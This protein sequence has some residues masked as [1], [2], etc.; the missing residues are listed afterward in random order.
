M[1]PAFQA[2]GRA[3]FTLIELLVVIAIIAV[4]IGLLLPAVQKVREAANRMQ[5]ANNL[6]QIGLAIHSYHDAQGALPYSRRDPGDTW[7]VLLMPYIEQ[8]TLYTRWTGDRRYYLQTRQARETPVPLYF[9]PSRR[10]PAGSPLSLELDDDNGRGTHVPGALSDYAA[11]SGNPS[12]YADYN[13]RDFET[14]TVPTGLTASNGCF[15]RRTTGWRPV[16]F[17]TVTD[18]LSN[19]IF[20]GEKHIRPGRFGRSPDLAIYNGDR[21]NAI[22]KKAGVGAAL[23]REPNASGSAIFGSW[24]PGVCQFVMG[25]GSVR[26]LAVSID[27]SALGWLAQRT[28]AVG[29][30]TRAAHGIFTGEGRTVILPRGRDRALGTVRPRA[31]RPVASAGS[32]AAAVGKHHSIMVQSVEGSERISF[33]SPCPST[34]LPLKG[35]PSQQA[36]NP[37]CESVCS[38]HAYYTYAALANTSTS[39]GLMMWDSL[40]SS[41]PGPT[42]AAAFSPR[43]TL[44]P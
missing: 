44:I 17:Q 16:T 2:R 22:T 23:A 36:N 7:A 6:K 24:H 19:T 35:Y 10:G 4:L 32:G 13:T 15:W 40:S 20:I 11:C 26:A 5:C 34:G 1:C 27:L 25:D 14:G 30:L 29:R 8:D 21:E 42:G 39:S 12:G 33:P 41:N 37:A 31:G 3:A 28:K 38:R 18:G 43:L 9:C